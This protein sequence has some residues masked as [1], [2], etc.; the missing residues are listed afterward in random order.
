VGPSGINLRAVV[1]VALGVAT[2]TILLAIVPKNAPSGDGGSGVATG[3]TAT[4]QPATTTTPKS[5]STSNT[6]PTTTTFPITGRPVLMLGA[7][8]P[9]V[10]A[11]QQRLTA[12]G[13]ATGTADGT[14]GAATETAVMNFQKAKNLPADGV[15]GATTWAA[16]AAG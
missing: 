16:L 7:S 9:D 13:Y 4:T 1:V 5:G 11:L 10:V 15:V 6:V 14:F 3:E 12:L 8:G 2:T